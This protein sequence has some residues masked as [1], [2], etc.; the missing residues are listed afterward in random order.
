[1]GF[2]TTDGS[3]VGT[4]DFDNDGDVDM[5]VLD[6]NTGGIDYLLENDGTGSFSATPFP[7][8]AVTTPLPRPEHRSISVVD[9]NNDGALD[10]FE[11][12]SE[13]DPTYRLL[14]NGGNTN[15]WLGVELVGTT[16]NRDGIGA[17]VYVT[18]DGLTQ[19]RHQN[20]GLHF[21][22]QDDKRLHFGLGQND[23]VDEIRIV[24]PSG[25]EQIFTDVDAGQRI[26][27]EEG[28]DFSASPNAE[29]IQPGGG[30]D[31]PQAADILREGCRDCAR[32]ASPTFGYFFDAL[33]AG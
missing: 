8:T 32:L 33:T 26:Q 11:T 6:R 4:G 12:S 1:M 27:I 14:E 21:R 13:N 5:L 7:L 9:Y 16:S 10:L 29:I 3:G 31:S 17:M 25:Q 24:W 22:V 23:T 2:R 30:A 20:G 19:V 15:S 18:A 28:G